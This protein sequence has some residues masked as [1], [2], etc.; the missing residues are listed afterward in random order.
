MLAIDI[1]RPPAKT[2]LEEWERWQNRI[3]SELVSLPYY[4][5]KKIEVKY[6]DFWDFQLSN[7]ED[8]VI[9]NGNHYRIGS[10]PYPKKGYG[11]GGQ[12]FTIRI[13]AT[14]E[15]VKTCD[16]WGQGEVPEFYHI[17]DT[18]EFIS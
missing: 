15:V 18:A 3:H 16:L 12:E 13:L 14:G 1:V 8:A 2:A 11:F 4:K 7:P 5:K 6:D 10:T 9:I 17:K